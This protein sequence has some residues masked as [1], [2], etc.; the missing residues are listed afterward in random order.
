MNS[1][2]SRVRPNELMYINL[3]NIQPFISNLSIPSIQINRKIKKLAQENYDSELCELVFCKEKGKHLLVGGYT[4]YYA[5]SNQY[6]E[7][8][9]VPC[10]IYYKLSEAEKYIVTLE[11]MFQNRIIDWNNRNNIVAALCTRFNIVTS[12]LAKHLN[13]EN[14]T[15]QY[16]LD[17]DKRYEARAR[18]TGKEGLINKINLE[19]FQHVHNKHYLSKLV[20]EGNVHI[21]DQ[22]LTFIRWMR[23]NGVQFEKCGLTIQQE[24]LLI[25]KARSLK[26]DFLH[27]VKRT[28]NKMR[29]DNGDPPA[30]DV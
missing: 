8:R 1:I 10:K 16:Y 2:M 18:Q 23:V 13:K 3:G 30:F 25:E 22:Q 12:D 15:I 5:Y 7:N 29:G 27:D 21:T 24:F 28:I 17:P 9:L 4:A 14:K 11:W 26:A 19:S 6:N 20:L